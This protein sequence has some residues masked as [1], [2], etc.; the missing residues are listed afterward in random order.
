MKINIGSADRKL[1]GFVVAP[2][3]IVAGPL[4]GPAGWL[5]SAL[6]VLAGGDAGDFRCQLLPSMRVA[7]V[8]HAVG[9]EGRRL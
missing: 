1:R 7:G 4:V 2:V 6:Y 8:G 5:A 3:L 9:A